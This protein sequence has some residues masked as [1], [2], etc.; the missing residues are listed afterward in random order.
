MQPWYPPEGNSMQTNPSARD[1]ERLLAEADELISQINSNLSSEAKEEYRLQIELRAEKL[2]KIKTEAQAKIKKK[3]GWNINSAA[4]GMHE[5]YQE[6]VKAMQE[7]KRY[8]S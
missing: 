7:L 5:A 1:I 4:E 6:I 8:L 3:A 2:N